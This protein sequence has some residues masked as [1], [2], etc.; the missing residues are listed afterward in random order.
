MSAPCPSVRKRRSA[1]ARI[2][3][4]LA[5]FV[6]LPA[7]AG[8]PARPNL[9]LLITVDTLRADRL[10]AFGSS[11]GL[12]PN[13]DALAA[14]SEV[15]TAAYSSAPFTLPS[16]AAM[17]TG[18]SPEELGIVDNESVLQETF[19]TL[20]SILW[21][22]GWTTRGIV[23]NFILRHSS[24]ID[25]GFEQFDDDFGQFEAVRKLPERVA[26]FTTEGALSGLDQCSAA[27]ATRC[28]IWVHYQDP[29]GP[30][31]AP[32]EI[33]DAELERG[34]EPPVPNPNV[35]LSKDHLGVGGLPTYQV[36]GD[37]RDAAYYVAAYHAEIR[38]VDREIG[39]LLDGLATRGLDASSVIAFSSDHGEG[40]GEDD[41]WFAHGEYLS[42]ALVRVPLMIRVPGRPP[43]VRTDVAALTDLPKTLLSAVGATAPVPPLAGRDLLGDGAENS[44]SR[45]YMANLIGATGIRFGIV[46]GEYKLVI[47][48]RDG[49][50]DG[51]LTRRG[52]DA[53]DLA[54]AAPQVAAPMRK[55]LK[56][57]RAR[58]SQGP[59][60]VRQDL[61]TQDRDALRALGYLE[62]AEGR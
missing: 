14:R 16:V 60:E 31:T 33:L 20:A 43:A 53:I 22:R 55:H 46:E 27:P 51:R 17:M 36:L 58:V 52:R 49:V 32:G 19:P 45:P 59:S 3:A 56:Q 11:L 8:E 12:T 15:F 37:H 26:V 2:R 48:M 5:A 34:I 29:H 30:Y 54:G 42:D 38:Y 40:L 21:E 61:S 57:I 35:P 47:T 25:R 50:W 44:E 6:L 41:Y 13:L 18:A 24:G 39:R 4:T 9:L 62:S 28:F 10:G 1:P 23:G 7:C